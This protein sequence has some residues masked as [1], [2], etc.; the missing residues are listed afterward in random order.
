[1]AQFPNIFNCDLHSGPVSASIRQMY[2]G[3]I[4]A[5]RVGVR[6]TNNGEAVT[7]SGTCSGTAMLYNG[8]TVALTGVV[9]GN[10]AYVDLPAAV[11]SVEGPLK[12]FVTLTHGGSTTT[13]L[14]M[15]SNVTR[16]DSGVVIDPGT[17]IPSVAALISDIEDAVA[18]IP[19]DYS[20]LSADV[21]QLKSDMA[22]VKPEVETLGE[23]VSSLKSALTNVEELTCD[24]E[25]TEIAVTTS[26]GSRYIRYSGGAWNEVTNNANFH[27]MEF[28]AKPSTTYRITD[29][30]SYS[31][32][33]PSVI[34]YDASGNVLGSTE[35]PTDQTW[36]ATRILEQYVT[37]PAGCAKILTNNFGAVP[38]A[39]ESAVYEQ[40]LVNKYEKQIEVNTSYKRN[41]EYAMPAGTETGAISLLNGSYVLRNTG[42]FAGWNVVKINVASG[43]KWHVRGTY[44]PNTPIAAFMKNNAVVS[45][46]GDKQSTTNWATRIWEYDVTVPDNVDQIWINKYTN[47]VETTAIA[48][49]YEIGT[50]STWADKKWVCIGDSLTEYNYTSYKKYYDFVQEQTG[51]SV[52]NLGIGGTGYKN[53][54]SS[55]TAFYERISQIPSDA[56]VITIFGS[57]ND[58]SYTLGTITDSGT[59]TICG[60]I[61]KTIDDLYTAFPTA[62]LGIISPC[63]WVSFPTNTDNAMS[64][65][66]TALKQIC[67]SRGIPFLDL[68][69]CSGIRP[70]D[71]TFKTLVYTLSNNDGVHPNNIGQEM[72]ASHI[73]EFV[74]TLIL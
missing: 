31:P 37:T 17:I 60:C 54:G 74:K 62:K 40:T 47:S 56:D 35:I 18:S 26:T 43:E 13:L 1:M 58:L 70:W 41:A 46:I 28:A 38:Y 67:E 27:T 50:A 15:R 9:D 24:A 49:K 51:I 25:Y 21:V 16:T 57:G 64:R 4:A 22:E 33:V 30:S 68:Y 63:P 53:Q 6:V 23:D 73:M 20:E 39:Y 14:E 71:D 66:S 11:Y 65:Y 36:A 12:V 10:V 55:Q 72:L 29:A 61:N 42:S 5:N 45:V 2:L 44:Y 34:F 3:D 32:Y 69:R 48:F 7:L 19:E 8:G 59:D 52:V